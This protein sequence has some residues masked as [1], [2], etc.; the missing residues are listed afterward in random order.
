MAIS[1][2]DDS[3]RGLETLL[4]L[5]LEGTILERHFKLLKRHVNIVSSL[6]DVGLEGFRF[7]LRFRRNGGLEEEQTRHQ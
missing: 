3:L 6:N 4:E 2:S 1:F 7:S 5:R